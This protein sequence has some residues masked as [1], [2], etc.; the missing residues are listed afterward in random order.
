MQTFQQYDGIQKNQASWL[1]ERSQT[2]KDLKKLR[3]EL[4]YRT[5]RMGA[6]A[7]DDKLR[8]VEDFFPEHIAYQKK[9]M[10]L[11]GSLV[12]N[13]SWNRSYNPIPRVEPLKQRFREYESLADA[14]LT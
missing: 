8:K 9:L 7:G 12:L 14:V 13:G 5:E 4:T 6:Y 10:D 11:L 1:P 3:E 2:L